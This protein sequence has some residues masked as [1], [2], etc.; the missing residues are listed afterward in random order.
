MIVSP[1]ILKIKGAV[2]QFSCSMSHIFPDIGRVFRHYRIPTLPFRI[3]AASW[4]CQLIASRTAKPN[5]EQREGGRTEIQEG[6]ME[7]GECSL[8]R[9]VMSQRDAHQP[10]KVRAAARNKAVG[11]GGGV[12]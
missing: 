9:A 12:V 2:H 11:G 7:G 5:K 3:S 4:V 1:F 8:L 6:R 10:S